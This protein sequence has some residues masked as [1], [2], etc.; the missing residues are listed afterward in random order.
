[1]TTGQRIKEARKKAGLT[2]AELA[3]KLGIPYQSISQW[4]RD[5]RNPKYDTLRRIAAAL[6]VD[7]MDLVPDGTQGDVIADHM[8]RK[9]VRIA[10][11]EVNIGP[12][13]EEILKTLLP[14]MS[15]LDPL[16]DEEAALKTLLNSMGYDIIKTRGEYFFTYENGGSEISTDDLNELLNCAQNGLKVAAKTL[17]LKLMQEAFAPFSRAETAP[18]S[19]LASN[20]GTDT[21][22]PP[23]TPQGPPEGE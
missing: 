2:Q 5:T 10:G 6:G 20:E 14:K 4:E 15:D 23:D 22:P 13:D 21:T 18:Q 9:I 12:D 16:T 19:S 8:M 7:W 11:A 3:D 1:M 17:E